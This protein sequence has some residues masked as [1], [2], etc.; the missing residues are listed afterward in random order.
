[1]IKCAPVLSLITLIL[2][3]IQDL[4]G[5]YRYYEQ[6]SI[7]SRVF[8][9]SEAYKAPIMSYLMEMKFNISLESPLLSRDIKSICNQE[10]IILLESSCVQHVQ[11]TLR[12]FILFK[13]KSLVALSDFAEGTVLD[14]SIIFYYTYYSS[15]AVSPES[16]CYYGDAVISLLIAIL[17]MNPESRLIYVSKYELSTNPSFDLLKSLQSQNSNFIVSEGIA[18]TV[19]D[20]LHIVSD[21][22]DLSK[23]ESEVEYFSLSKVRNIIWTRYHGDGAANLNFVSLSRSS[24]VV[25]FDSVAYWYAGDI[26]CDSWKGYDDRNGSYFEIKRAG[27]ADYRVR[28]RLQVDTYFG[29][30]RNPFSL[31]GNRKQSAICKPYWH[32]FITFEYREFFENAVAIRNILTKKNSDNVEIMGNFNRSRYEEIKHLYC[33]DKILQIAIGSHEMHIFSTRYI[34][35]HT[36]NRNNLMIK[37]PHYGLVVREAAAVLVYSYAHRGDIQIMGRDNGVFVVPM[38]STNL[39]SS[40][41][42]VRQERMHGMIPND[43]LALFTTSE[44]RNP[45]LFRLKERTARDNISMIFTS[46]DIADRWHVDWSDPQ[47]R[48]FF[49]INSKIF[50]NFHSHDDS[51]LETHRI[52]SLLSLGVCVVSER[53]KVDAQ[54][55]ADYADAVYILPNFEEMYETVT[56]L[57][58][59][60]SLLR[61]CYYRSFEKYRKIMQNQKAIFEAVEFAKASPQ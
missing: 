43:V 14:S 21:W 32:I 10:G 17:L 53:S 38:F 34:I 59:N 48:E 40:E 52:N 60:E 46:L 33:D 24:E 28:S 39:Q 22:K 9:N 55:D 54:L 27:T 5:Q 51:V 30:F 37:L 19:C 25:E 1:M 36:E 58:R 15:L 31:E 41:D 3:S 7:K 45:A 26:S 56:L 47:T 44:K 16:I 2:S 12:S 20:T 18:A 35:F 57:L 23:I 13:A 50:F 6:F 4:N 49:S 8:T 11:K 29:T 42:F 61:D